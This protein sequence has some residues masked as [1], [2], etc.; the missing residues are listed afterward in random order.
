MS[1]DTT[2]VAGTNGDDVDEAGLLAELRRLAS[3]ID[4]VPAES[5]AA[6]RSAFAWRTMDA[7]LADLTVLAELTGDSAVDAMLAGVRSS[8]MPTM[9]T[10]DAPGLTIEVEVSEVGEERRLIGQL[11]PPAAGAVEVRHRGGVTSV[12]VDE[13]GRFS[14]DGVRAGPVSLRCSAPVTGV[15]TDWF[16]A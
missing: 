7:E 4:P 12:A 13:V 15:E 3:V 8:A 14:I 9:L 5:V 11:V 10:F 2:A 16:L 1:D 6:A